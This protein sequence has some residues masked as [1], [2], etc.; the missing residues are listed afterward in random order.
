MSKVSNKLSVVSLVSDELLAL[1]YGIAYEVF[2]LP[3]LEPEFEAD[4][5]DFDTC[6]SQPGAIRSG[7]GFDAIINNGLQAL[8]D[9][10]LIVIPGWPDI[11]KPISEDV[12]SAIK[13]AHKRG[14]RIASLC[15]G[16]VVLA[17]A[18][19]LAGR[20]AT[21]H[22]RFI[23]TISSMYPEIEF[24]EDVLYIDN[25]DVL[26]AAGSAAGID[27]C[28]HI[29]R[30]DYGI[31]AA[32]I[33]AR[34]LIMPPHRQGGQSQYI[35]QP[36]PKTYEAS[37]IGRVLE[38]MSLNLSSELSIKDLASD[39]GMS[40]RTFQRRFEALTGLPPSFWILQERLHL[41]CR[42]LEVKPP[43]SLESVA[44]Q[45]GFG[46]ASTMRNHFRQKMQ[47]SPSQYRKEFSHLPLGLDKAGFWKLSNQRTV[48]PIR[49]IY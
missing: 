34:G 44:I 8:E 39:A 15:S 23:D 46:S 42:L 3:R 20:R 32:N 13:L 28:L 26:T 14:A 1:E 48:T 2:G 47:V 33:V 9:A 18:G 35:P 12:I 10:D 6:T 36:I 37:R 45:S 38:N 17:Q 31:E 49:Q 41:A 24:D 19:L 25:D 7:G 5:Y 43:V 4:W 22:W 30:N 16:V 29:V 40:V 11:E 21:T 27:L